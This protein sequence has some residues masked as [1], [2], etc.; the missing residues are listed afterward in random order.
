MRDVKERFLAKV[1]KTP[2]CWLWTGAKST[3]GYGRFQIGTHQASKLA[4][5]HRL[6]YEFFVGPVPEGK[7]VCHTC[8]VRICVNP[9]HLFIGTR[10]ENLQDASRK[11][12]LARKLT[13]ADARQIRDIYK[14]GGA[15]MRKLAGIFGVSAVMVCDIVRGKRWRYV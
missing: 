15:S 8:D 9:A 6:S 13:P 1:K 12:R 2:G 5:A 3:G 14:R 7:D 10:A 11:G 4:Q